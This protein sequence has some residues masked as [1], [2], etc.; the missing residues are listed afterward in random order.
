MNALR[1]SME[2]SPER[3]EMYA[4]SNERG[5]GLRLAIQFRIEPASDIEK[6]LFFHCKLKSNMC[7]FTIIARSLMATSSPGRFSLPL[8]YVSLIVSGRTISCYII[9]D[10]N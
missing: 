2:G 9:N 5:E 1:I 4:F 10:T 6:W 3:I 7:M 8:N